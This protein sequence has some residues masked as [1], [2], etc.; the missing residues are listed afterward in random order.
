MAARAHPFALATVICR[1]YDA[2]IKTQQNP[3][4]VLTQKAMELGELRVVMT[5]ARTQPR[6]RGFMSD[7][8]ALDGIYTALNNRMPILRDYIYEA[9]RFRYEVGRL[10]YEAGR[11][12]RIDAR[13]NADEKALGLTS[14]IGPP[15]R[16]PIGG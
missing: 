8:T 6:V 12:R 5:S 3:R 7:L 2:Y 4:K 9:G 1:A 15:P 14:C 10:R 11:F 13:V 16:H